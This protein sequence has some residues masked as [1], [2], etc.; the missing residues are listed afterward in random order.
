MAVRKPLAASAKPRSAVANRHS[1]FLARP[2]SGEET[3]A[4]DLDA[5][6]ERTTRRFPKTIKRLAE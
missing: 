1:N 4:I 2:R 3:A 5:A 6:Y